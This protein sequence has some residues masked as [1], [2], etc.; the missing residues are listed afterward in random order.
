MQI[1][2]RGQGRKWET[3]LST[4]H[5]RD[6]R[7]G[8]EGE[9]RGQKNIPFGETD[10]TFPKVPENI[11]LQVQQAH[12]RQGRQIQKNPQTN[13]PVNGKRKMTHC[14]ERHPIRL[15]VD[16]TSGRVEATGRGS[17]DGGDS[18]LSEKSQESHTQQSR[19]SKWKWI[20]DASDTQKLKELV[21]SGLALQ[22][23]LKR[24]RL[25]AGDPRW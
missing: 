5:T 7:S 19:L 24:F 25:K 13:S 12:E 15:A 2:R 21:A 11:H 9:S 23:V 10:W 6:G 17:G 8:S 3:P 14:H 4:P 22:K 20:K 18:T 16:F 1:Q